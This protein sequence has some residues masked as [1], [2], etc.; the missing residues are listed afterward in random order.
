MLGMLFT[1]TFQKY[2]VSRGSL[3][4]LLRTARSSARYVSTSNVHRN[5]DKDAAREQRH[6]REK[7]LVAAMIGSAVGFIGS[8][9]V[10]YMKLT[11]AKAEDKTSSVDYNTNSTTEA[12]QDDDKATYM[13]G[14]KKK[15]KHG[16]RER[17]VHEIQFV[18]MEL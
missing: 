3:G 16:F 1:S 7:R 2:N 9:Y 15:H 13:Y 11:K 6:R 10:L 14:K 12:N 8:S 17:R 5:L 18:Y 4:L